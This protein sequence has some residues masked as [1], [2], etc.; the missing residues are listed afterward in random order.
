MSTKLTYSSL[1]VEIKKIAND[2]LGIGVLK[3]IFSYSYTYHLMIKISDG[4]IVGFALYH[5]QNAR[6]KNGGTYVTGVVDCVCVAAP[7]R[8][9]GFGTS[10]TFGVL[11]KMSAHGAD[12]VELMLKSPG[13]DDRDG[14]PGVPVLGS[15]ELLL[16]LGFRKVQVYHDHYGQ[17]SRQYNY[18]CRFCGNKPDTC[19]AVLYAINDSTRHTS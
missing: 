3:S 19:N 11:R 9:E 8:R 16:A 18:D 12:R 14:E 15:E 2:S 6:M 13:V 10:L 1:P 4:I 7:Y 5:F 17:K